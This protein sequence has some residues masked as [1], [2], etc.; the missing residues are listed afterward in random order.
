LNK[1]FHECGQGP[2][3]GNCQGKHLGTVA[4]LACSA[5]FFALSAL[6]QGVGGYWTGSLGL[7]SDALE[8]LNDMMVN[9][10]GVASLTVANRRQPCDLFAYGWHRLEVFNTLAGAGFLLLLAGGVS[11]EAIQRFRHPVAIR[12]GWVLLFSVVGLAIN[13]GAT[14]MLRPR[15]ADE[16]HRDSNLKAAYLHAFSDALTSIALVLSMVVIHCTGWRWVDPVMALLIVLVILR[17]ALVLVRDAVGILMHRAA[18]DHAQA[19]ARLMEIQGVTGVADL[20]SWKVCSHLVVATAH[21]QVSVERLDETPPILAEIQ[22]LMAEVYQVRHITVHF[23]TAD[24][25]RGH[26]HRFNHQHEVET[27]EDG[28]HG[29]GHL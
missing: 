25:A 14:L 10:L 29:H 2:H 15:S 13:V 4:R 23:E 7:V 8:N 17:G 1:H 26:S 3:D 12:T 27:S 20:R 18:F 24:M 5:A 21:V 9:L 19:R 11:F 16:S 6:I 22:C 28:H